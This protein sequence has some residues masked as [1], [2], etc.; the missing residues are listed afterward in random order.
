MGSEYKAKKA[1]G[2]V[3]L[4]GKSNPHAYMAFDKALLN[5]RKQKKAVSNL[6]GLMVAAQKG[7]RTGSKKGGSS[8]KKK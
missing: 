7:A 4:S 6:K 8:K 1:G 5:K 3:K 2:D